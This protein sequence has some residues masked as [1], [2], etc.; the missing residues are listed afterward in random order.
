[1]NR[2]ISKQEALER[3]VS[4]VLRGIALAT[5]IYQLF[6]GETDVGIIILLA[7]GAISA[8][9]LFTRNRIVSMPIEFELLFTLMVILQ[10]VIGETLDFYSQVP[11]YD[12]FVHF[13]LP[14]IVGF[15]SFMIAYVLYK[16]G[17]LRLSTGPL[18]LAIIFMTLGVGAFWEVV[19]YSYDITLGVHTSYLG[20]LQG[21]ASENAHTDTMF[22][23][24][25]DL[26][27]GMLGALLGLL[28]I[29]APSITIKA[30]V[31]RFVRAARRSLRK[32]P[33]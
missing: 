1:M 13:S 19:E 20:E 22:D 23:L 33:V 16:A 30:R 31:Q 15:V 32:K 3:N 25:A 12:K 21:N 27:G 5:G 7:V 10:F 4:F 8:P 24:I 26:I 9:K 2:V 17:R 28:F 6:L 18:M 29:N 14:L 11:Y